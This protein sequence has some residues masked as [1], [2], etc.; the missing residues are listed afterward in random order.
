M[1]LACI[2]LLFWDQQ[3]DGAVGMPAFFAAVGVV[4]N[5][6]DLL[7]FPLVTLGF[8]L[9]LLLCLRL[10]AG[11]SL[12]RLLKTFFFCCMGWGLGFGGMWA[13]KWLIVAVCF[14][15]HYLG[16]IFS[17]VFLRVSAQSNGTS[18]SRF[19]ALRINLNILLSKSSYLLILGLTGI[20]S[21]LPAARSLMHKMH[22]RLD[23]RALILLLP[24]AVS[25]AWY[26]VMANHSVDH[27]YYTYRNL[28][29]GVFAGFACIGCLIRTEE[30]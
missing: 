15:W 13:L 27:A 14:G 20:A 2:A 12:V 5:F 28:A 23:M 17:Q 25:L 3:I 10:K 16:N 7:T 4:T 22:V 8:P 30:E 6:L 18:F 24:L 26:I 19:D 21:L 29:M 11:D 9:V 1:F